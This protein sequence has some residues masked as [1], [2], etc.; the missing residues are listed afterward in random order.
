MASFSLPL[1]GERMAAYGVP[2]HQ[3]DLKSAEGSWEGY[4]KQ[5]CGYAALHMVLSSTWCSGTGS[6]VGSVRVDGWILQGS[7]QQHGLGDSSKA[8]KFV[9]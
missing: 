7:E 8:V 4:D 1:D 9:Q 5:L 6:V 2:Y 3:V